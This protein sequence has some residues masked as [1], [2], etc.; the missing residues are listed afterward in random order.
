MADYYE[1]SDELTY[2]IDIIKGQIKKENKLRELKK[3]KI[4]DILNLE[5]VIGACKQIEVN[6]FTKY[7]I[8]YEI[9]ISKLEENEDKLLKLCK[10]QSYIHPEYTIK[11]TQII[12]TEEFEI[13][14]N[15]N[16]YYNTIVKNYV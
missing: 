16:V 4:D 5:I 3:N 15:R 11:Y 13:T 7:S 6:V 14:K 9:F 10:K 12:N 1:F 2:F 8:L